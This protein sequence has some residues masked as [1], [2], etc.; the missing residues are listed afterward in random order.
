MARMLQGSKTRFA[1]RGKPC[2]ERKTGEGPNRAHLRKKTPGRTRCISAPI[3]LVPPYSKARAPP[4]RRPERRAAP[5]RRP[6]GVR[7]MRSARELCASIAEIGR[8]C[9]ADAWNPGRLPG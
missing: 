7:V 3:R 6:S 2:R 1:R 9:S 4:K 5:E 8:I